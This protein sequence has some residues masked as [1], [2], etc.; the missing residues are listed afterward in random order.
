MSRL[1]IV[2]LSIAIA[3]LV[4]CDP[5]MTIRQGPPEKPSSAGPLAIEIAPIK[6]LI[7]SRYYGAKTK[8]TNLSKSSITIKG[9][10]LAARNGT[11]ESSLGGR[12]SYPFEVAPGTSMYFGPFFQLK[13]SVHDVFK[14][15]AELRVQYVI[16]GRN[17][18]ARTVLRGDS[19][20]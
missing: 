2:V 12:E 4:A 5:G 9:C 15:P 17:E 19:L 6:M 11:Y 14:E 20:R 10:E 1:A 3:S 8:V 16:D 13:D 18:L 7:G